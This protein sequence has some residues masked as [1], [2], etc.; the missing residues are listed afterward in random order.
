MKDHLPKK[1]VR[2]VKNSNNCVIQ[3][4]EVNTTPLISPMNSNNQINR[5]RTSTCSEELNET[6]KKPKDAVLPSVSNSPIRMNPEDTQTKLM[7][8]ILKICKSTLKGE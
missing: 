3:N 4:S 1:L 7:K 8:E 5:K 2:I 6:A